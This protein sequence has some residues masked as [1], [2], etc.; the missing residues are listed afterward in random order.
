MNGI[1]VFKNASVNLEKKDIVTSFSVQVFPGKF[2][3]VSVLSYVK[4]R[5][6]DN[7][8]NGD[9]NPNGYTVELLL[10]ADDGYID[11]TILLRTIMRHKSEMGLNGDLR[12][13]KSMF[14]FVRKDQ[15]GTRMNFKPVRR[16]SL[17]LEELK[18]YLRKTMDEAKRKATGYNYADMAGDKLETF[19]VETSKIEFGDWDTCPCQSLWCAR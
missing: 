4:K 8:A 9:H 19:T 13:F 3:K 2:V 11:S 5:A 16:N 10:E 1:L 18:Y 14:Q 17:V 6:V 7:F 12:G 15:R